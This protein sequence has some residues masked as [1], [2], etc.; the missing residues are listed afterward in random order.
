MPEAAPGQETALP[1]PAAAQA[2]VAPRPTLGHWLREGVRAGV[3]LRPR[4]APAPGPVQLVLL[5]LLVSALELG[6]G[7]LEVAGPAS[8][9]LRGWLAP[10][11]STGALVLLGW[12]AL[13]RPQAGLPQPPSLATWFTLWTAATVPVSLVSQGLGI[14]QAHE[15]LPDWLSGS[16]VWSWGVYFA[17]WA[18]SLAVA[19]LLVRRQGASRARAGVLVLGLVVVFAITAWL[20]PDRPWRGPQS[21]AIAEQP[22]LQL[23]Q[24]AFETQQLVWQ[25]AVAALAPE[26]PGVAD[27]YG[28]VFAPYAGEDVF[29]RESGMVAQLLAERFDATGRV[30]HLVNNQATAESQPWAT[31]QNLARAVEALAARMDLEHDILVVYLTSHG[32]SDYRLAAAHPPLEV[33]PI[34]PGELREA[35]DKAGI[36]NRVIAVSACFSGGWIGPLG[37]DR[38]LVM[39]AADATHTSYGCGRLSELTFFGRAVFGEQLRQKT[40]SFE[41]AFRAAVPLIAQREKEA[42]KDD[43]FSNPQISVGEQIRPVLRALE[44]RLDGQQQAPAAR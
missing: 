36:R 4:P 6:L 19:G 16:Q 31:P 29:M 2:A 39:T 11:W 26:R 44:Q 21:E 7:R 3:F 25:R 40:H 15:R 32:A 8:F 10:W 38:S 28:L 35:L 41:Q 9:D 5:L 34:S 27:V 1:G 24:Q 20:F 12:W 43:G 13:A 22:R 42:G 30:L 23:S 18:W 33:E 17:L 14:A 37:G